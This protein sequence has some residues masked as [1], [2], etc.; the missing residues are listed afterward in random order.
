MGKYYVYST[1]SQDVR[2][3][4]YSKPV[5]GGEFTPTILRSVTIKGGTG[6]INRNLITPH[7]VVT[8]IDEDEHRFLEGGEGQAPDRTFQA[9]KKAGFVKVE[10]KNFKV[11][12]VV[13]DL[14]TKDKSAQ[15]TKDDFKN[16]KGESELH[17]VG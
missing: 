9:L 10:K 3:C 8:A 2:Y 4:Q 16:Q 1:M 5:G 17:S 6:V 12:K 7:G 15:K 13:K 11:E 14:A